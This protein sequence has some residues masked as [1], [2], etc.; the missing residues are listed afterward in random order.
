M[1]RSLILIGTVAL[2]LAPR[3]ST[4][5]NTTNVAPASIAALVTE[6]LARNPELRFY[7]AEI[8]A[9]KASV[10]SAGTWANPEVS[11]TLGH[12]SVS[13]AGDSVAWSV[14]LMQPFEWPGRIPLR[15]AIAN[16]DVELAELGLQ[17]FKVTLAARIRTLGYA[18]YSAQEKL[19]VARE[20]AQRYTE[21]SDVLVQ[22]D[23]AG[24]TA[25]LEVRTIEAA[26]LGLQREVGKLELEL[27]AALLELN[28]LRGEPAA[29]PLRVITPLPVLQP[30]PALSGLL[31]AAMT[32]RFELKLLEAELQQRGE[33]LQLAE[34]ERKSGFSVGPMISEE[35]AGGVDRIVGIGF[36]APLPLWNKNKG[37][38]DAAKA[39]QSQAET[40]LL[41]QRRETERQVATALS[42]YQAKLNELAKWRS[43]SP[44]KFKESA[45]LA[46]RH[47]RLGAVPMTTYVELQKQYLEAVNGLLDT[48]REALEAA[49]QLEVLTG[50]TLV[51]LPVEQ[52]VKP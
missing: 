42:I 14:A 27:Q 34:H 24:L 26:S 44:A 19:D 49:L 33:R 37:N 36:S 8:A 15:K 9:A 18:L 32:N 43:D 46:D 50:T 31:T 29:T 11:A 52:E 6:S 7:E 41:V 40:A 30:A 1:K 12:N 25:Q 45:A 16:R 51:S 28:L 17:K 4:A 21:L 39:R 3:L 5:E 38:I 47:Y 13:G 10:K 2:L 22:R 35:R 20:A 23:P 48:R